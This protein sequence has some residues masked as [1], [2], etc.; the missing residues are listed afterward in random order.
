MLL[1]ITI[2]ADTNSYACSATLRLA[3]NFSLTVYDA[4]YLELAYPVQC[5]ARDARS[6]S[7]RGG[8]G[9]QHR[10]DWRRDLISRYDRK[11][12][13]HTTGTAVRDHNCRRRRRVRW[14]GEI[15]LNND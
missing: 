14:G 13:A 10:T 3:E 11:R 8:A 5:A 6:R 9:A 1:P 12:A 2:D 7:A 4:A 15:G